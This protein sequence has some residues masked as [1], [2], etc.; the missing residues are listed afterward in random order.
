M[1]KRQS[2]KVSKKRKKVKA[3]RKVK[4]TALQDSHKKYLQARG[5]ILPPLA[6]DSKGNPLLVIGHAICSHCG[7]REH[8]VNDKGLQGFPFFDYFANHYDD[9][10]ARLCVGSGE[11]PFLSKNMVT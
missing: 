2:Y 7:K 1:A 6:G 5:Y 4:S 11:R 8:I 9:L 3:G 10:K